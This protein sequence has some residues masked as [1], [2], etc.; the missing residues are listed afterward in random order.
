MLEDKGNLH[1]NRRGQSIP[2]SVQNIRIVDFISRSFVS[3]RL[4]NCFKTHIKTHRRLPVETIGEYLNGYPDTEAQFLSIR[5]FGRK[6][7]REL[8]ELIFSQGLSSRSLRV[9]H[10]EFSDESR[11]GQ[12]IPLSVQNIRIVDFISRSY[13]SLRLRSCIATHIKTHR[14][15]PVETIGEYLNSYPDTES[16]FLSIRNFGRKC[17]RELTELIFSQG[18]S[19]RSLRIEHNEF[20]DENRRGQSTPLSVQNIRIIDVI[21]RSF[22]SVRLRNCFKTHIKTHRRLPVETIGEYLNGY[23]HTQTQ[24]LSIR[25][26]GRQC[27]YELTELITKWHNAA[28]SVANVQAFLNEVGIS[29][30]ELDTLALRESGKSG[31]SEIRD[32]Q[33]TDPAT[34]RRQVATYFE[35]MK[36]P[37]S[38]LSLRASIRLRHALEVFESDVGS[39]CSSLGQFLLERERWVDRIGKQKGVGKKTMAEL[40]ACI[41]QL[42]DTVCGNIGLANSSRNNLSQ[43]LTY[44]SRWTQPAVLSQDELMSL[45]QF[46]T[47]SATSGFSMVG[48]MSSDEL[49]REIRRDPEGR[50][51]RFLRD[52]LADRQFDVLNRRYGIDRSVRYTLSEIAEAYSVSRERIRQLETKALDI[53]ATPAYAPVFRCFLAAQSQEIIQAISDNGPFISQEDATTWK[54][55]V[56]GL[57]RLAIEVVHGDFRPW[58]TGRLDPL[59]ARESIVGWFSPSATPDERRALEDW[60][61][62]NGSQASSTLRRRV[63]DAVGSLHWP[64]HISTLRGLLPDLSTERITRCLEDEL[65]AELRD[66]EILTIKHLPTAIRLVLVL[67]DAGRPLHLTQ[68]RARHNELF[69]LDCDERAAGATLQR[70]SEALIVERGI[71]CLYDSLG[72]TKKQVSMIRDACVRNLSDKQHFLSAKLLYKHI[73]E[74]LPDVDDVQF[75]PYTLLGICQDDSRFATRRGLMVGLAREGFEDTFSSLTET[76]HDIV[77]AHGPISVPDLC[78]RMSHE[79]QVLDVNVGMILKNSPEIVM[80]ARGLYDTVE[81]KIGDDKMVERLTLALQL[82]LADRPASLHTLVSRLESVGFRLNKE[83]VLSFLHN[84]SRLKRTGE[85]VVLN[86]PDSL[87]SEYNQI[88]VRVFD[89]TLGSETN[90]QALNHALHSQEMRDLVSID[91]RLTMNAKDWDNVEPSTEYEAGI[92]HDLMSDFEF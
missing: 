17:A 14:R 88:F 37:S 2:L 81:R 42:L 32:N 49:A 23:P 92:L 54:R 68:I 57:Q 34:A 84:D 63:Q 64:C 90:K 75:N 60:F 79:R 5:N 86:K 11:R 3:V 71:Y 25:N 30:E 27:A 91:F 47:D 82:S 52:T 53:C 43:W 77:R 36:F 65:G 69:G 31:S 40:L 67:R 9:E 50:L 62:K 85:L 89:P 28:S 4:R 56:S 66:D 35:H 10:A 38:V 55:S 24:F 16:Q 21:S 22:V 12:S 8:T 58:V 78:A 7:A 6:C 39:K 13:V 72:L 76:I 74:S 70:L 48:A 18:L 46:R 87:V 19:S 26:F 59:I 45:E 73:L 20:S 33:W 29:S 44:S 61:G 15:L 1:E 41:V 83:T 80:S 51:R